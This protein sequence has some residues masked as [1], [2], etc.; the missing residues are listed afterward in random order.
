MV[1]MRRSAVGLCVEVTLSASVKFGQ[2]QQICS[3][4]MFDC[5]GGVIRADHMG[6]L[7]AVF[8]FLNL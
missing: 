7:V 3:A 1:G 5:L 8:V 6:L 4:N 2:C